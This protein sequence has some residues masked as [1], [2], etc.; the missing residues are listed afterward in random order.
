V[1]TGSETAADSAPRRT[2]GTRRGVLGLR[3]PTPHPEPGRRCPSA[4]KEGGHLCGRSRCS[5]HPSCLAPD[6]SPATVRSRSGC[7]WS[8]CRSPGGS[9]GAGCLPW[10]RRAAGTPRS[11]GTRVPA[12]LPATSPASK[13]FPR[14]KGSAPCGSLLQRRTGCRA[15]CRHRGASGSSGRMG[16]T[17]TVGRTPGQ[18]KACTGLRHRRVPSLRM[19]SQPGHGRGG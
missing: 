14:S 17:G 1:A 7:R 9:V 12:G 19:G 10:C 2:T 15:G 18:G 3:S 8:G 6:A 16:W 13:G 5:P 4:R 11:G